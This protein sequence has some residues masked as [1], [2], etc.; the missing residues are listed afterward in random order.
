MSKCLV[1]FFLVFASFS[2]FSQQKKDTILPDGRRA[3]FEVE[4]V[5]C[6]CDSA[7]HDSISISLNQC[8]DTTTYL[9]LARS[10]FD[11]A[12]SIASSMGVPPKLVYEIGMNE[13]RWLN[14]YD[15][16]YLI[17]DGDLQVIDRTFH[18]FY[19]K[20]GLTGGKTR[21]NY[22]VVAIYYLKQNYDTYHSWKKARYAYGRG[23][24]KPESQ[25]SS[26]ERSFMNKI[27]WSKYDH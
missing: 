2:A 3:T 23:M 4:V 6:P 19:K 26:L 25:W 17:K 24:W 11:V 20:L 1:T 13:S 12:D 18:H 15:F 9:L 21:Y 14:P 5:P 8:H 7:K 27:D 10:I 22:L 16:D